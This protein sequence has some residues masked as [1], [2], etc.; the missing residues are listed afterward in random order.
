M[1][2]PGSRAP[3]SCRAPEGSSA[4]DL[5]LRVPSPWTSAG[6]PRQLARTPFLSPGSG[7]VS[8]GPAPAPRRLAQDACPEMTP[9]CLS[10]P[11]P[12]ALALNSPRLHPRG[13]APCCLGLTP[14]VRPSRR[15]CFFPAPP[16]RP[17]GVPCSPCQRPRCEH[18]L[19]VK[20]RPA[21]SL[22][23]PGHLGLRVQTWPG[24]PSPSLSQPPCPA[25]ISPWGLRVS[26]SASSRGL[27]GSRWRVLGSALA[28]YHLG[29]GRPDPVTEGLTQPRAGPCPSDGSSVL[30]S[31]GCGGGSPSRRA[32]RCRP[33]TAGA[34]GRLLPLRD[35]ADVRLSKL[36]RQ[37]GTGTPGMLPPAGSQ[38]VGRG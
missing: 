35:S 17:P 37:W 34:A 2:E 19:S 13:K 30:F 15:P 32:G 26:A 4:A 18:R 8:M 1:C 33:A 28:L 31:G 23:A 20:Q 27:S 29:G 7:L 25:S 16:P 11:V 14:G 36:R 24:S 22:T 21:P 38:R 10:R 6:R 9:G 12:A 3:A 5:S